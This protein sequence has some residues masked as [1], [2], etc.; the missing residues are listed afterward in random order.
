MIIRVYSEGCPRQGVI[1]AGGFWLP[2]AVGRTKFEVGEH[3]G[4]E[5][6]F[7]CRFRVE[8]TPHRISL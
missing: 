7:G 5:R 8:Y 3:T 6:T 4:L 2:R 1:V